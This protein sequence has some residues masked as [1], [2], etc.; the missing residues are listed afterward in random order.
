MP[1]NKVLEQRKDYIRN[2]AEYSNG[3]IVIMEVTSTGS[4]T[5]P[6]FNLV[7]QVDGSFTP[8]FSSPNPEFKDE[9]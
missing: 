9:K 5:H 8:N 2:R 6:N 1:K 3:F 7:Q 4:T